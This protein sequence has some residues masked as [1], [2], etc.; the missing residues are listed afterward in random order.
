MTTPKGWT[1]EEWDD[2]EEYFASL[3][4]QEQEIELK[5]LES[6]GKV[7]KMGKIIVPNDSYYEM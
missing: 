7:K 1:D 5:L 3:S 6:M 2:F 4:C